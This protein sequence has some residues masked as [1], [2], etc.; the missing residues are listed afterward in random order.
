MR[1]RFDIAVVVKDFESGMPVP[2]LARVHGMGVT[3][4]Y[5]ALKQ[6]GVDVRG[7]RGNGMATLERF[8]QRT[9]ARLV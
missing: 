7:D 8:R 2:Q 4:V 3:T 1:R 6:A 5:V 9:I